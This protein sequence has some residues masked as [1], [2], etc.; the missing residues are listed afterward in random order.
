MCVVMWMV[1]W[2][3]NKGNFVFCCFV[4]ESF[5]MKFLSV[6]EMNDIWKVMGWLIGFDMLIF[7]LWFFW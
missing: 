5:V 6:V 1:N 7:E 4:N 3:M 2:M